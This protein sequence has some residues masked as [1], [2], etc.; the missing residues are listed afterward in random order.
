MKLV[1][2]MQGT[3]NQEIV[4]GDKRKKREQNSRKKIQV[5]DKTARITQRGK[6]REEKMEWQSKA[7][8]QERSEGCCKRTKRLWIYKSEER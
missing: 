1:S 4:W 3:R 5:T 7:P 6:Q 8:I 2:G